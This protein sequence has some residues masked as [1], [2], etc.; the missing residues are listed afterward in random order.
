MPWPRFFRAK[1]SAEF[2]GGAGVCAWREAMAQVKSSAKVRVRMA[3]YRNARKLEL[4]RRAGVYSLTSEYPGRPRC[5]KP[6]L[7]ESERRR[8]VAHFIEDSTCDARSS[9]SG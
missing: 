4:T 1:G 3:K 6:A 2:A 8:L 5:K 7:S 9:A